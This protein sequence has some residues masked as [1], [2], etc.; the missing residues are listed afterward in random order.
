VWVEIRP[1]ADVFPPLGVTPSIQEVN[2][3]DATNITLWIAPAGSSLDI[4]YQDAEATSGFCATGRWSLAEANLLV[5][6]PGSIEWTDQ[7]SED[8][9][10]PSI[11]YARYYLA[12]RSDIDSDGDG[13]PDAREVFVCGTDPGV[14]VV[15][16]LSGESGSTEEAIPVDEESGTNTLDGIASTNVPPPE[17]GIA[18]GRIIYVDQKQGNDSY[19]GR[20]DDVSVDDGP[21]KTIRAG[22]AAVPSGGVLVIAGGHYAESFNVAGRKTFVRCQGTVNVSEHFGAQAAPTAVDP[23]PYVNPT[24][25][26]TGGSGQ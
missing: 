18:L 3:D 9:A 4:F 6:D 8:R 21:K 13:I 15:G 5:E 1:Y 16:I 17:S 14:P 12:A 26:P 25:Q 19:S 20:L 11:V 22:L 23:E 10:P 2:V 24:N 7:G